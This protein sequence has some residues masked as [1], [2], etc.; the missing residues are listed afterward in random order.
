MYS[1]V[2]VVKTK[3]KR[4]VGQFLLWRTSRSTI[5]AWLSLS[6]G[7][8]W[9]DNAPSIL[10]CPWGGGHIAFQQLKQEKQGSVHNSSFIPF[11]TCLHFF[12]NIYVCVYIYIYTMYINNNMMRRDMIKSLKTLQKTSSITNYYP[13]PWGN[14]DQWFL[15]FPS[16][17]FYVCANI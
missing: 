10:S 16:G 9:E 5:Y 1:T 6:S 13:I 14:H 11:W 12:L 17:I 15:M 8:C 3:R 7:G 2:I 4:G